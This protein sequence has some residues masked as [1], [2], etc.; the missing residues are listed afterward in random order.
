MDL[1]RPTRWV[2]AELVSC[3]A[4]DLARSWP[5]ARS[6]WRLRAMAALLI[7]GAAAVRHGLLLQA[8]ADLARK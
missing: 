7:G 2:L 6:R 3:L 4:R 5:R 8:L 1:D